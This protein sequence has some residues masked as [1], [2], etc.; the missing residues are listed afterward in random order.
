MTENTA[1][2]DFREFMNELSYVVSGPQNLS[3][4]L[5]DEPVAEGA[6]HVLYKRTECLLDEMETLIGEHL[7]K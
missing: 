7:E 6:A 1:A 2:Q 4:S 5:R 3:C